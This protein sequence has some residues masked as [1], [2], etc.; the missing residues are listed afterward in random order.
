MNDEKGESSN[1]KR[2][3]TNNSNVDPYYRQNRIL[4]KC[5]SQ[6][7]MQNYAEEQKKTLADYEDV[8]YDSYQSCK[9][10][11]AMPKVLDELVL[12][13]TGDFTGYE[14]PGLEGEKESE[15]YKANKEVEDAQVVITTFI[16]S[17]WE[18][19]KSQTQIVVNA[20]DMITRR[21]MPK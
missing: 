9:N 17:T 14:L 6:K 8:R 10:Q 12:A 13:Y 11:C 18:E 15:D 7:E 21:W 2:A 4:Q 20:V 16:N 1:P 5:F 3:K 19:K